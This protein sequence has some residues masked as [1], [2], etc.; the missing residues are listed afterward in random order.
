MIRIGRAK[1]IALPTKVINLP[2]S[3]HTGA[4]FHRPL[5]FFFSFL[6]SS[7]G[8]KRASSLGFLF[9]RPGRASTAVHSRSLSLSLSPARFFFLSLASLAVQRER[10][11]GAGDDRWGDDSVQR[12]VRNFHARTS[13]RDGAAPAAHA[14]ETQDGVVACRYHRGC[15]VY[16]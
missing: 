10:N 15:I 4:R 13:R 5:F 7:R 2:L 8:R 6:A 11:D 12:G 3:P 1:S 16:V 14:G 9:A